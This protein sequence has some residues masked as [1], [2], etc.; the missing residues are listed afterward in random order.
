MLAYVVLRMIGRI[1]SGMNQIALSVT[2]A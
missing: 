1:R 2:N